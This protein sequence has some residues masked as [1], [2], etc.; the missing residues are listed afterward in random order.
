M[1][2]V[3][4][5]ERCYVDDYLNTNSEYLDGRIPMKL[6]IRLTLLTVVAV[7]VISLT[8]DFIRYMKI[9]AM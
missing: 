2:R 6:L 1:A 3:S 7:G 4:E 8:P 5:C 9:R